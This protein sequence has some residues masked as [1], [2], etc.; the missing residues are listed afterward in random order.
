[1]GRRAYHSSI[2]H[3]TCV[4]VCV[5]V[6]SSGVAAITFG[7]SLFPPAL[8]PCSSRQNT[9]VK[10]LEASDRERRERAERENAGSLAKALEEMERQQS[11]VLSAALQRSDAALGEVARVKEVRRDAG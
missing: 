6:F 2:L 10:Q 8:T 4:R 1:M 9:K 5:C 11:G 3:T 7:H